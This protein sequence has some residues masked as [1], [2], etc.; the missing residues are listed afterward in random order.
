MKHEK[1]ISELIEF[2]KRIRLKNRE[3]ELSVGLPVN[4]LSN[5]LKGKKDLPDKYVQPIEKYMSDYIAA[6]IDR[7]ERGNVNK[8]PYDGSKTDAIK[9]DDIQ[10]PTITPEVIEKSVKIIEDAWITEVR[11]FCDKHGIIPQDLINAWKRS[12]VIKKDDKQ[13][14]ITN[15]GYD[16]F[17]IKMGIK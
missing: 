17:K 4:S 11:D 14:K 5:F 8:N 1:L 10:I 2:I 13:E 7:V 12:V 16:R 15:T 9:F 3:V 6:A